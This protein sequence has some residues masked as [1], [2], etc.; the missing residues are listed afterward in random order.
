MPSPVQFGDLE[1]KNTGNRT[2][3]PRLDFEISAIDVISPINSRRKP[4]NAAKEIIRRGRTEKRTARQY[5]P[6]QTVY[7]DL[8]RH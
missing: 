2:N 8:C 5:C 6:Y 1:A 7:W 4:Y 3:L